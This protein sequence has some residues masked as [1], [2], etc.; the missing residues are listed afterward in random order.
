VIRIRY[1]D[2]SVGTHDAT[3]LYGRAEHSAR[4]VT[5]YLVP[6]LTAGQRQTALRRLRQ[7]ASR[8]CGPAL[9]R[10]QLACAL[11]ADHLRR[12]AGIAGAVVRR[13][14]A[15]TL[16]PGACLA[17]SMALFVL[18]GMGGPG[19]SPGPRGGLVQ[20]AAGARDGARVR[21]R[22]VAITADAANAGTGGVGLGSGRAQPQRTLVRRPV[23]QRK[24]AA[25]GRSGA[26]YACS[27][28]P[29]SPSAVSLAR[30]SLALVAENPGPGRAQRVC[31]RPG[32][33]AA[34]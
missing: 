3:W 6:G 33:G 27:P 19:I 5:V 26:W 1:K 7:E 30:V 29:A 10:P 20:A 24:P 25:A 9:P 31:H 14:P 22:A 23:G 16:V 8:G 13:H 34:P 28:A 21:T 32:P 18:A 17:V 11:G 15:V 12:A 2:F 4:G